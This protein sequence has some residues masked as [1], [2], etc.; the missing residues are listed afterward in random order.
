M[1]ALSPACFLILHA[2]DSWFTFSVTSVWVPGA[3]QDKQCASPGTHSLTELSLSH[4]LT[5]PVHFSE[6]SRSQPRQ[7]VCLF[8]SRAL[9][10]SRSLSFSLALFFVCTP[11]S[12]TTLYLIS[13]LS[14]IAV[15]ALRFKP[16][17]VCG[18]RHSKSCFQQK[19]FIFFCFELC[20]ADW[21]A[22]TQKSLKLSSPPWH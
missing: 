6:G 18:V 4:S 2:D 20:N 14:R 5:L 8:L 17:L 22:G 7:T 13:F 10:L 19:M 15:L 12:L 21:E 3:S 11:L 9:S 1:A 16:F